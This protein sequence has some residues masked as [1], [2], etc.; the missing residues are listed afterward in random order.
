MM[1]NIQCKSQASCGNLGGQF[2]ITGTLENY[3][4]IFA[5]LAKI[6]WPTIANRSFAKTNAQISAVPS[7]LSSLWFLSCFIQRLKKC[8][9]LKVLNYK[10]WGFACWTP[11][12]Y[13]CFMSSLQQSSDATSTA[14]M[15]R[16]WSKVVAEQ[17]WAK[18]AAAD[19]VTLA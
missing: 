16:V 12:F 8:C 15:T 2:Q 1:P 4:M 18:T 9:K 6:I 5:K 19:L 7:F 11:H 3:W 13:S 10:Q 14:R 17:R